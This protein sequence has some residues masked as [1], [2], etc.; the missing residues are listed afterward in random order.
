MLPLVFIYASE[1][2]SNPLQRCSPTPYKTR[3]IYN[4]LQGLILVV[5]LG[6]CALLA[7]LPT[8]SFPRRAA[9]SRSPQPAGRCGAFKQQRGARRARLRGC[10]SGEGS[11]PGSARHPALPGS[12]PH[13]FHLAPTPQDP[14]RR[15][16]PRGGRCCLIRPR[17]NNQTHPPSPHPHPHPHHHHPGS[18]GTSKTPAGRRPPAH[19]AAGASQPAP[20][21]AAGRGVDEAAEPQS[22]RAACAALPE[23]EEPARAAPRRPA[24]PSARGRRAPAEPGAGG[25]HLSGSSRDP[26]AGSRPLTSLPGPPAAAVEREEARQSPW[27][28]P[29]CKSGTLWSF[30]LYFS[31]RCCLWGDTVAGFAVRLDNAQQF[32]LPL[33]TEVVG[34]FLPLP[35]D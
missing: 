35:S 17:G 14:S 6:V 19:L 29:R 8:C 4:K 1:T 34:A 21:A 15:G 2:N 26:A 31:P 24:P 11:L 3:G 30:P 27:R 9:P 5:L 32:F 28:S 33:E 7:R 23:R 18:P 22:R 20:T 10:R 16:R 25:P 12:D 13:L